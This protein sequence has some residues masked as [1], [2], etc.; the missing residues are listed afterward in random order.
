MFIDVRRELRTSR[1]GPIRRVAYVLLVASGVGEGPTVAEGV[2]LAEALVVGAEVCPNV[3]AAEAVGLG[4][5]SVSVGVL[6]HAART[7]TSAKA[8]VRIGDFKRAPTAVEKGHQGTLNVRCQS[9][10]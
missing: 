3:G 4:L 2:G 5:A 1:S 8:S 10:P 6:E 9:S 7:T